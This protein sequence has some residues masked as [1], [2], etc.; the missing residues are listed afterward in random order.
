MTSIEI[1]F[2]L[3]RHTITVDCPKSEVLD[4]LWECGGHSVPY[5]PVDTSGV[6]WMIP[7]AVYETSII[8]VKELPDETA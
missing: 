6:T 2:G 7:K 1:L 5:Y 8:R 4:A 3:T